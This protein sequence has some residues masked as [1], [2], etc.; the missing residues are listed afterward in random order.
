MPTLLLHILVV[1]PF[2]QIE[3]IKTDAS[4]WFAWKFVLRIAYV[5]AAELLNY[6]K[7]GSEVLANFFWR[8][9]NMK[10]NPATSLT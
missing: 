6:A 7:Y 2:V 5:V 4:A 3:H 8:T 1:T 9:P 10:T